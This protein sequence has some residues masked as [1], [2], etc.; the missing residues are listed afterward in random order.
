MRKRMT[1][2]M[3]LLAVMT[4]AMVAAAQ[5]ESSK[6][7]A[8]GRALGTWKLDVQKSDFGKMPPPRSLRLRITEDTPTALKW[9]A[10]GTG[11]DGK[12]MHESF[13]G[14]ADGKPYPITGAEG[15]TVAYTRG[16]NDVQATMTMKGGG[17]LN[18]TITLSDDNKTMTVKGEGNGPNGP[19]T[20]TEVWERVGA[21]GHSKMMRP[22]KPAN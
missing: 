1:T 5:D 9:E 13:S 8:Q 21:G 7:A 2:V 20:L 12:P 6:A 19:M 14:A 18:E 11:P 3:A 22:K 17:T 4:L 15:T 16:A 10:S